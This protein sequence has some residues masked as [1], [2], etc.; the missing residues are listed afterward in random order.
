MEQVITQTNT[1]RI[2]QLEA[3]ERGKLNRNRLVQLVDNISVQKDGDKYP[4]R[5][6]FSPP[7][8]GK[9]FTV[10]KHLQE[11]NVRFVKVSGNVSMFAFG[12]QLAVINYLNPKHERVVI[13]VDDC[14]EIFRTDSNC[15]TMKNVLDGE[16]VFIYEKSLSSQ[17]R[18]LS[19]LQQ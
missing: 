10:Q 3:I 18:N 11:S 2:A 4:H 16:K 17:M 8:L 1:F 13:F 15:N 9:T 5:Y 14:D 7:G 6:I 19:D 12:I